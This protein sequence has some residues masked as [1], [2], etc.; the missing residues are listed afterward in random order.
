M[1][2]QK[3]VFDKVGLMPECY[4][5]GGEEV[6]FSVSIHKAGFRVL[7]T[8]RISCLHKV[9]YS[10]NRDLPF[11]YNRFRN[12]LL[13]MDH[14]LPRYLLK[15][16]L[17]Y[18]YFYLGV[19]KRLWGLIKGDTYLKTLSLLFRLAQIDRLERLKNLVSDTIQAASAS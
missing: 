6:D 9:G 12:A 15:P 16:W 14:H 5:L 2:I 3:S 1:M 13:F 4:F 7:Y 10:G 19:M 17:A 18:Q 8:P 11:V